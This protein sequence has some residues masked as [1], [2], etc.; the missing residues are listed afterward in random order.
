MKNIFYLI[1]AIGVFVLVFALFMLNSC[2]SMTTKKTEDQTVEELKILP[3]PAFNVDSAFIFIEKQLAFGPR[4]P[5]S[6]AHQ[7]CAEYLL[8]TL[9]KMGA[10]IEVQNFQAT[11]YDSLKMEGKNIIASLN[12]TAQR[13][14]LLAAHW[15]TRRFSDKDAE[16]NNHNKPLDGAD[17]GASG[18]AVLLEIVRA[19]QADKNKPNVG[20]DVI[21]FDLEDDGHKEGTN[22][23]DKGDKIFWCHG[24]QHWSKNKHKADYSAYFGILLDMVGAKNAIFRKEFYSV[25]YA[26]NIVNQTWLIGQ[27]L[28]Y[29]QFFVNKELKFGDGGMLDDHLFVNE[30]GKIP[31]IDIINYDN[32]FGKHH[33]TQEDNIKIIDKNTLKAV[34]ET[35]LQMIYQN[36]LPKET[37][38]KQ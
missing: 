2:N 1:S 24:S 4:T 37:A 29:G 17:D 30:F 32:E 16:K 33:H 28:G 38:P 13:R 11:A 35:V 19:I 6:K 12:P 22:K 8:K 15:D 26:S 25:Q 9:E 36:A 34:G 14:I 7:E 20:I 3:T 5:N 23:N 10:N 31:M 27:K 21:F 18:V